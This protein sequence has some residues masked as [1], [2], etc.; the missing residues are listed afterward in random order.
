MPYDSNGNW[1]VASGESW[2]SIASQVYGNGRMSQAISEYNGAGASYVLQPGDVLKLPAVPSN[3]IVTNTWASA[4]NSLYP[5]AKQYGMSIPGIS[6]GLPSIP[7]NPSQ[8]FPKG[9]M[10]NRTMAPGPGSWKGTPPSITPVEKP[11]KES[12]GIGTDVKQIQVKANSNNWVA[13]ANDYYG[14]ERGSAIAKQLADAN[15]GVVNPKPGQFINL[16]NLLPTLTAPSS[17]PTSNVPIPVLPPP[18]ESIGT[19]DVKNRRPVGQSSGIGTDVKATTPA[20]ENV[21]TTMTPEVKMFNDIVT[22]V[23]TNNDASLLPRNISYDN[24]SAWASVQTQVPI[25]TNGV[26]TGWSTLTTTPSLTD[27]YNWAA[28]LDYVYN[29]V[30]NTFDYM[31][32]GHAPDT[33]GNGPAYGPG[34]LK[35][36]YPPEPSG[37]GSSP[38]RIEGQANVTSPFALSLIWHVSA[39]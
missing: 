27:M 22:Q 26:M 37:Y 17:T 3:V 14:V 34:V 29:P 36:L 28:S 21:P 12:S 4:Q 25:M 31:P 35:P 20:G 2:E 10:D 5:K 39:G 32:G 18:K 30:T 11:F 24:F 1:V 33:G 38:P 7:S 6:T 8:N 15:P 9:V 16:P 13:I 19:G 23:L